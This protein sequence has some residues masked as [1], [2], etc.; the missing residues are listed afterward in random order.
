MKE[1]KLNGTLIKHD[2]KLSE[3]SRKRAHYSRRQSPTLIVQYVH[4]SIWEKWCEIEGQPPPI[5]TV[6]IE[7]DLY[8]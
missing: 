2:S 5:H 3:R 4:S 8:G 6:K 1:A 7:N